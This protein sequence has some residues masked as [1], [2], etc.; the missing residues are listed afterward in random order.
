[1][2]PV[3]TLP[4]G[5][6]RRV[7]TSSLLAVVVL[8]ALPAAA[9]EDIVQPEKLQF[10]L[11]QKG[12]DAYRDG[13]YKKAIELFE[14]SLAM[15]PLN[16]TYLNL[17]RA[18]FKVGQC[19]KAS[20]AYG[21]AR[22]APKIANPTPMQVLQKIEEYVAE[23][24]TSCP[25]Y[26]TLRCATE[27]MEVFVD[28]QGPLPCDGKPIAL[29]PGEHVIRGEK[30]GQKVEERITVGGMARVDLELKLEAAVVVGEGGKGEGDKG[31]GDKVVEP[32]SSTP[33]M[34]FGAAVGL[35]LGG[36]ADVELEGG[37]TTLP[38]QDDTS[39]LAFD[40][41]AAFKIS[42]GLNLYVGPAV[43]FVPKVVLT[44]PNNK[45]VF[46]P[47]ASQFD[48]DAMA[49][50]LFPFGDFVPFAEVRG[51]PS[52][53]SPDDGTKNLTGFNFALGGGLRW[54]FSSSISLV[55]GVALH[56]H[57][58]SRDDSGGGSGATTDNV[59][60][61]QGGGPSSGRRA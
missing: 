3:R 2:G 31:E 37:F 27:G 19:D 18:Y 14:A 1:M 60:G 52:F 5:V 8:V 58:A 21:K 29:L 61:G 36:S 50:M 43:G 57:T 9:D 25:A 56:V 4:A 47:T 24:P 16:L 10:E 13:D 51:G 15:G 34:M 54:R 6:V 30:G 7:A 41:V 59:T 12:S 45:Q 46:E 42:D 11:Y 44:D 39:K 26:L 20:E 33:G 32:V 17:G 23:L 49:M 40:V 55:A 48:L 53:V 28:A 38:T 22:T 35:V